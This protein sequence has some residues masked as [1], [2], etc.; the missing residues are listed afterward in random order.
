MLLIVC[1]FAFYNLT[2]YKTAGDEFTEP[3]SPK[4][5]AG[6]NL[7]QN[8]NCN[9]CHQLYGLGGYLGPDLTN[10]YTTSGK[11]P[12]YIKGILN[13]GIGTMPPF[14][15][16]QKEKEALVAFLEEVDRSGYYP[17]YEADVQASGWVTIQYKHDK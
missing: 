14:H 8:Y 15:F 4:A 6:K 9:S 10:V 16:S 12:E 1:V 17:N 5:I 11:G 2:I 7:W 13:S 3:F